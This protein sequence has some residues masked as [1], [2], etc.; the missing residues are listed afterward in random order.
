M[1]AALRPAASPPLISVRCGVVRPHR[2]ERQR[3]RRRESRSNLKG[4]KLVADRMQGRVRERGEE[5]GENLKGEGVGELSVIFLIP[6]FLYMCGNYYQIA[7]SLLSF[8]SCPSLCHIPFQLTSLGFNIKVFS[9]V[10]YMV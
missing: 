10:I 4:E 6:P 7:T 9:G 1:H 2:S 5:F 8:Q 3:K